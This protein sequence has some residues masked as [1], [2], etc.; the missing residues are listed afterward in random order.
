[1]K[2]KIWS[3]KL[4][5]QQQQQQ[6]RRWRKTGTDIDAA[7]E[8]AS[9]EKDKKTEVETTMERVS[10][11]EGKKERIWYF[12]HHFRSPDQTTRK[13]MVSEQGDVDGKDEEKS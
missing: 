1:M 2:G 9:T 5:Q 4:L 6:H 3:N 7:G 10:W 8:G 13:E 11:R 12:C